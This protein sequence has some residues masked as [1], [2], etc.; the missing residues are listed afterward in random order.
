VESEIALLLE[1]RAVD[2]RSR[3]EEW[4]ARFV[5]VRVDG[6][7]RQRAV[8][9]I[10]GHVDPA[11]AS[12]CQLSSANSAGADGA[13]LLAVDAYRRR[14][15]RAEIRRADV[16]EISSRWLAREVEKVQDSARVNDRLRLDA[17]V[18]DTT[19]HDRRR[20]R[21][22]PRADVVQPRRRRQRRQRQSYEDSRKAHVTS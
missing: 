19:D 13:S 5:H 6:A 18:R 21:V 2:V 22:E 16:E 17:I 20:G 3:V 12:G 15:R 9:P 14:Q 4:R 11:V 10:P 1:R 7:A 8:R